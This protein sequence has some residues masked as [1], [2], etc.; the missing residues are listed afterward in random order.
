MD[1]LETSEHLNE[2]SEDNINGVL[3]LDET[4]KL[5]RSYH[6]EMV[7]AAQRA[8]SPSLDGDG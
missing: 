8:A 6:D 5:L 3:T 7:H 4:G 1:G 2:L